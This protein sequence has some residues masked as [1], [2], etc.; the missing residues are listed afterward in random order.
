MALTAD[1]LHYLFAAL[2]VRLMRWSIKRHVGKGKALTYGILD[3]F[4]YNVFYY[5]RY[6]MFYCKLA[7]VACGT[8]VVIVIIWWAATKP[9]AA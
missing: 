3:G 1:A 5:L 6:M 7:F 4:T 2:Q 9:V 8:A